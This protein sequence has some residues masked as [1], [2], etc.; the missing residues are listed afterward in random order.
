MENI[1]II[2]ILLGIIIV[3]SVYVVK[4]KKKGV[5]CI[6]C[7]A[8]GQCSRNCGGNCNFDNSGECEK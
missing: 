6:G 3:A 4:Q 8:G 2:G 1:I 5:K 7:P